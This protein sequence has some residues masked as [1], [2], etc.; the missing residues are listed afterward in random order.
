MKLFQILSLVPMESATVCRVSIG[1]VIEIAALGDLH[2][3]EVL[4]DDEVQGFDGGGVQLEAA[5]HAVHEAGAVLL[6]MAALIGLAG[7]MQEQGEVEEVRAL[8]ADEHLGVAVQRWRL[9]APNLIQLLQAHERVLIGGVLMIE[10]VL[11]EAG[12]TAEFRD[13]FP[14]EIDVVHHAQDARHVTALAND[15][16]EC[17]VNV[18]VIQK[19]AV[20][21][22]ELLADELG[23]IRVQNQTALL[24][25]E[26][27]THQAARLFA[28]DA[29]IGGLDLAFVKDET[30]DRRGLGRFA[31]AQN[32]AERGE[33]AGDG[34]DGQTLFHELGDEVDVARVLVEIAHQTFQPFARRTIGVTEIMRDGGLDALGQSINRATGVIMEVGADAQEVIV[35]GFELL[36]F[37]RAHQIAQAQF[38]GGAGADLEERHPHQ[39][40]EIAQATATILDVRLLHTGGVAVFGVTVL[41]VSETRGDVFVLVTFDALVL[42]DLLELVEQTGISGDETGLD[43]R[44]LGLHVA[45]GDLHAIIQAAHRGTDLE[46]DVVERVEQA[47]AAGEGFEERMRFVPGHHAT[48]M[49]EHD[50]DIAVRV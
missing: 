50:I 6:V 4:L 24:G 5:A 46:A 14:E 30:I 47:A 21:Q 39:V 48:V 37:T 27:H 13:V 23:Q 26:K 29:G 35:S 18:D 36:G 42:D 45:V 40:L 1:G 7:I 10:L 33:A 9:G 15:L 3:G 44:G 19:V 34:H 16:E 41:L 38:L 22:R 8:Q 25:V 49:Q 2:H 11:D 20:H 43:E 31:T 12:E 28:K 32:L 17:L